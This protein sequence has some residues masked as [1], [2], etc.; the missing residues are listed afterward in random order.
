M[1]CLA[2]AFLK[3]GTLNASPP[4][5]VGELRRTIRT[6]VQKAQLAIGSMPIE[7]RLQAMAEAGESL[8][9]P[10]DG[11]AVAILM[12]AWR[13]SLKDPVKLGN[14]QSDIIK[15]MGAIDPS[16]GRKMIPKNQ[17]SSWR[18]FM[19]SSFPS[20]LAVRHPKLAARFFNSSNQED[21]IE[22]VLRL[23]RIRTDIGIGFLKL[24]P[25]S[26]IE[27]TMV[28]VAFNLPSK[29]AA[30]F[31]AGF[32]VPTLKKPS[33]VWLILHPNAS[34]K[35][36]EAAA[37]IMPA[38]YDRVLL[39]VKALE[40]YR[41]TTPGRAIKLADMLCDLANKGG[42]KPILA[43]PDESIP[44]EY[45][46]LLI[47]GIAKADTPKVRA[48]LDQAMKSNSHLTMRIVGAWS[49]IDLNRATFLADQAIKR[50]F[51]VEHTDIGNFVD[52]G[53]Q[54]YLA[55][56]AKINPKQAAQKFKSLGSLRF[57]GDGNR[58][59]MKDVYAHRIVEQIWKKYPK[60]A[61][62]F[63]AQF[64]P[65]EALFGKNPSSA[66]DSL[67]LDRD[68]RK[69]PLHSA[70]LLRRMASL[71]PDGFFPMG[72]SPTETA[73][74]IIKIL[75]PTNLESAIN[76]SAAV[77]SPSDR[78]MSLTTAVAEGRNLAYSTQ[79]KL[80]A[81]A[82]SIAKTVT[83]ASDRVFALLDVAQSAKLAW[84]RRQPWPPHEE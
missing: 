45:E 70:T 63:C 32:R 29:E 48:Y 7:L 69:D 74:A 46:Y 57:P 78:A 8:Q 17:E 38:L 21:L 55:N 13:L 11:A 35:E 58:D 30:T 37:Q 72:V 47:P 20:A 5:E 81:A 2:I 34:G 9:G 31:L 59:S 26:V 71:C 77:K 18:S 67:E 24:F 42:P 82:L 14:Y 75:A 43:M 1:V 83:K 36:L 64:S 19:E 62:E 79:V 3:F 52:D 28:D 12:Q 80:L 23:C 41:G 56:L 15:S 33:E 60:Q 61:R 4:N 50:G 40:A 22:A 44:T 27:R 65:S 66:V 10:D 49:M 6:A 53:Y 51:G 39:T 76:I 16:R 84:R 68:A 25:Q 73:A 54:T